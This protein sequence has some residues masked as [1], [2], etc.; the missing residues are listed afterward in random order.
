MFGVA[1]R[2]NPSDDVSSVTKASDVHRRLELLAGLALRTNRVDT[3]L[4]RDGD[5]DDPGTQKKFNMGA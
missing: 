5:G 4:Q 1:P 2:L 3:Q